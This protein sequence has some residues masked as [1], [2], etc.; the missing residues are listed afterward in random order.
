M[1]TPSVWTDPQ[2]LGGKPCLRGHRISV[3]QLL[4]EM[5]EGRSIKKLSEDF[6][7]QPDLLY[8]MLEDLSLEF[9]DL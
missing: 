5:S 2:R 7:L 8:G 1:N 3:S 4:A 6:N 9:G